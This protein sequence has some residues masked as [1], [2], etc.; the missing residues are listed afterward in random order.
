M[1]PRLIVQF[2]DPFEAT[3]VTKSIYNHMSYKREPPAHVGHIVQH[4]VHTSQV[5]VELNGEKQ[6]KTKKC[7]N[8]V[9]AGR[10]GFLCKMHHDLDMLDKVKKTGQTMERSEDQLREVLQAEVTG[11]KHEEVGLNYKSYSRWGWATQSENDDDSVNFW[12]GR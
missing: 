9:H 11:L 1:T 2:P 6:L 4:C 7:F 8:P 12:H 3:L 5:E 10:H